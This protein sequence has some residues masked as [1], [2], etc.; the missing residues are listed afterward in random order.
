MNVA[1]YSFILSTQRVAAGAR[2]DAKTE[3]KS[4]FSLQKLRD[5]SKIA[6]GR[7]VGV[8]LERRAPAVE[9]RPQ[10]RAAVETTPDSTR[11]NDDERGRLLDVYC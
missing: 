3:S 2:R 1:D 4:R 11:R 6:P 10:R 8:E 9:R 7:R 5:A